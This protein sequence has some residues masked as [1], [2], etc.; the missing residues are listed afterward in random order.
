MLMSDR[1]MLILY[2]VVEVYMLMRFRN[3]LHTIWSSICRYA[4]DWFY[5]MAMDHT[6]YNTKMVM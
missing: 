3:C 6:V 5:V 2:G 1:N 4:I